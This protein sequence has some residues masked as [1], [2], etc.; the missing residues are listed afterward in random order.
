MLSKQGMAVQGYLGLVPRKST[1]VG[2]LRAIGKTADEAMRLFED[3]RR[4]DDA[5]AHT[6]EVE[7]VAS[8]ALAEIKKYSQLVTHSIG[9]GSAGDVIFCCSWKTLGA[10][11]NIRHAMPRLLAIC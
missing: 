6:V 10:M 8:E 11:L 1:L 3:F 4:L 5:G 2:G 7:C 9:S